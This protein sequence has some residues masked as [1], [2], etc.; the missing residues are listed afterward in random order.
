MGILLLRL[1]DGAA[2]AAEALSS[3]SLQAVPISPSCDKNPPPLVQRDIRAA[4]R[5]R[6][7]RKALVLDS[8]PDRGQHTLG[9]FNPSQT[10]V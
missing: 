3:R 9:T 2:C 10:N 5:A 1:R 7:Y 4:P 6:R 8:A